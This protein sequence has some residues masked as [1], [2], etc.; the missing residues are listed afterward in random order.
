MSTVAVAD[1]P[2]ASPP[3]TPIAPSKSWLFHCVIWLACTSNS[4]ANSESVFSPL[5]A[6]KAT[7][8]LKV[9]VW[10]RR[11]RLLICSPHP[12]HFRLSSD[13][14]QAGIFTVAVTNPQPGGGTAEALFTVVGS[15]PI[16]PQPQITSL[17]PSSV[18]AGTNSVVLSIFGKNFLSNCTVTFNGSPR[19]V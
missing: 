13:L 18:T 14:Q 8:A 17:N 5:M 10:F 2:F 19:T 6:A 9:A 16:S 11:G 12:S 15:T 1:S 3:K 7:F 4:C